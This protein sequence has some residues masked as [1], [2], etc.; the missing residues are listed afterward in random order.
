M[1][2]KRKLAA[3]LAIIQAAE[4]LDDSTALPPHLLFNN[5]NSSL[6]AATAVSLQ[7]IDSRGGSQGRPWELARNSKTYAS[8]DRSLIKKELEEGAWAGQRLISPL[9][10]GDVKVYPFLLGDCAFSLGNHMMKSSSIAEAKAN[11]MLDAWNGI[12]FQTRKAV[13]CAFRI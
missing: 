11:P 8:L 2:R 13:E 12:D 9:Q 10:V 1:D 5:S 3:L 4:A 6:T 7:S